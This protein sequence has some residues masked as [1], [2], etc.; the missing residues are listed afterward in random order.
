MLNSRLC[1][2]CGLEL[3]VRKNGVLC[4]S[5]G[6]QGTLEAYE[7]DLHECPACKKRI[8]G[9]V[10]VSPIAVGQAGVEKMVEEAIARNCYV[11]RFWLNERE[12]EEFVSRYGAA[13]RVHFPVNVNPKEQP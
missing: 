13:W 1:W 3:A 5:M 12:R 2:D 10:G 9:G 11:Q 7:G 4:V 6:T 8:V